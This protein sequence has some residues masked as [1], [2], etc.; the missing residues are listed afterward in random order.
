MSMTP[1][2]MTSV[3]G[4]PPRKTGMSTGAKVLIALGVG[5]GLLVLVCCGSLIG[6]GAYVAGGISEDPAVIAAKTGE[7]TQIEVPDGLDPQKSM[8]V[9]FPFLGRVTLLVGYEDEESK[10]VLALLALAKGTGLQNQEEMQRQMEELLRQQ[11]M[12]EQESISIEE[13]YTKEVEIRGQTATFTIAKGVGDQTGTPRIQ[14]MG[15]F[16]GE[17]GPVFL[18][19]N[20]DAEEYTEEEVVAMIESIE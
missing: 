7:I 6:I 4:E 5:A 2:E 17:I 9:K 16:Q 13:S 18:M 8:D 15:V 14:V 12:G 11:G 1:P 20:A 19:F 10:S 3:G